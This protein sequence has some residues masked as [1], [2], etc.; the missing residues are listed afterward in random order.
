[1][2]NYTWTNAAGGD[3]SVA[4]NWYPSLFAPPGLNDTANFN[5]LANAYT[6]TVQA[7]ETIGISA[8]SPSISFDATSAL[9]D[10]ALSISGKLTANILYSTDSGGPA[11][12]L[13]IEAGGSL[14]A[15]QLLFSSNVLETVTIAG[16]GAGGYLELGGLTVG[17]FSGGKD[18]HMILDFA[19]AGTTTLNT[20]VIQIDNVNLSTPPTATQRITDVAYGDEIVINGAD[21]TGDTVSLNTATNDLTVMNGITTVFT[22]NNFSLQ[23]G[24]AN[25]FAIVN[26]DTIQAVCYVRG[27]MIRTPDGERAVE[28]LRPGQQ[29][30]TQIDGATVPRTIRWVG[31]RRIDLTR[32]P[33][34]HVMGPVRIERDAF[35][36][37]VP[38]R[39]LLLSPDHAVFVKG[40]LICV[41]QLVNGSTIRKE[42]G[43]TAVEYYHLELDRHAIV[44]AEG[45]TVESYLDT[46]NRAF[47]ANFGTP[48]VLHPDLPN[49]KVSPSRAAGSCAPFVTD[50]TNVR[51]VWQGL[52]D[53]G[54]AIGRAVPVRIITTHADPRLECP[55]GR[56]IGPIHSDNERVL[57]GLPRDASEVRLVSRAQ[58]PGEAR[59]WLSDPR[60]LGVRVKRIVVRGPDQTRE[61]AMDSPDLARG[62]WEIEHNGPVMSRWTDGDAV[63]PLSPTR[64]SAILEIHLAGEMV[65]VDHDE[66]ACDDRERPDTEPIAPSMSFCSESHNRSR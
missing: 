37:N 21:F 13:T 19:N 56:T 1:M 45:L 39:D 24:A 20:G 28:T 27:T 46:G 30:I 5:D 55:C 6:V 50:D 63:L 4:G 15:P 3:W 32:H 35:A 31:H 47:F 26:K 17:G 25:D 44:L 33:R 42:R 22:M 10:A 12:S 18:P 64:G 48:L 38:H 8:L 52:A 61:V 49:E 62:W 34:P 40:M 29:V 23:S 41:R 16:T 53:R 58:A 59:P 57:F 43:W 54:A 11:T 66:S 9:T 51:S 65:Y 36:D 7:G 2:G 60:R 14:I